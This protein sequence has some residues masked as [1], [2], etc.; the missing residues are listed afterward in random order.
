M[1]LL[2]TIRGR[3]ILLV[4]MLI[5]PAT[6]LVYSLALHNR[7]LHLTEARQRLSFFAQQ[8]SNDLQTVIRDARSIYFAL[9]LVPAIR[10][11][12]LA[13]CADVLAKAHA[14]A[15]ILSTIILTDHT[16]QGLCSA[17]TKEP[18]PSYADREYIQRLLATGALV[19]DRPVIG[20]T[21]KKA[22]VPVAGPV[23]ND[24]GKMVGTLIVPPDL[25]HFGEQFVKEHPIPGLVF[26]LWD[27]DGKL[28][29]RYPDAE[30]LTGKQ[31]ADLPLVHLVAEKTQHGIV[32]VKGFD[33]I[34]RVIG[35]KVPE[36]EYANTGIY[37]GVSMP[38]E[39]FFA[40]ANATMV[41]AFWSMLAITLLG[42]MAAWLLGSRM[43]W[44][45]I[46]KISGVA[47]RFAAGNYRARFGAPYPSGELGE[48][49]HTFDAMADTS[50]DRLGEIERIN[51]ELEQRI[52]DRTTR[53][54]SS[55]MQFRGVLE[56]A[57][58]AF[59]IIDAAGI[60]VIVNAQALALF[61]YTREELLGLP[62]DDLLPEHLRAQHRTHRA[63]YAAA[64]V[65]TIMSKRRDLKGRRKDG[66]EFFAG[67]SLSPLN[68]AQGHF[69]TA[70]VRDITLELEAE[71][72]LKRSNRMLRML[73]VCNEALVRAEDEN[74]LL[75]AICRHI[76]EIGGY[77]LA[78]VG[79]VLHDAAQSV[80][81]AAQF[82]DKGYV[83]QLQI[84][85]ADAER[86]RGPVGRAVREGQTI[87]V[88]DLNRDPNFLPWKSAANAH[89]FVSVIALPLSNRKSVFG[90]LALYSVEQ[91]MFDTDEVNLLVELA[92]DLAYGITSLRETV[93]RQRTQ[94][95]LDYRT[96]YDVLT[97]LPNRAMFID[98]TEQALVHASRHKRHVGVLL[99][100][101][102]RFKG[103]N[104]NYGRAAGDEVLHEIAERLQ[105]TLREGDTVARL[106]VDEFGVLICDLAQTDD[107]LSLGKKLLHVV[108]QPIHFKTSEIDDL[109]VTGSAGVSL[110]PRDG[111]NA[112]GLL[113]AA[114]VAMH[115][116]KSL[117]GNVF[118]FFSEE[119][120]RR[121]STR[122]VLEGALRRAVEQNEL[123][124][125]YQP[126]V[127]LLS[128]ATV[129][130]EA[131]VRWPQPDGSMISP[132]DFIPLAEE[133]GLI[134]P[135]GEWVLNTVCAQMQQWRARQLPVLPIAINLSARQ[136]LQ[137]DLTA[138]IRG[139]LDRHQL[140]PNL[141][142]VEITES[143][144]M[145]NIDKAVNIL[146]EIKAL[147]IMISL[148]DFGTGYSSLN[149]L[150]RFPVNHLKID[151]AFVRDIT[152][153]PD[154]AL[155]CKAVIGLAHNLKMS[156]IAEGV[157]TEGQMNYLRQH[158][159]DE[160]QGYYFSRALPADAFAALLKEGRCLTFRDATE[161]AQ[162]TLLLV[163]DDENML[164]ALKRAMRRSGYRIL[165]AGSAAEGFELLATH[166]VQVIISD[167][168]MPV[169]SGTA[170]LRHVKD[171]YP[172]TVRIV[173]SGYTEL[174]SVTEAINQ[175]AIY[176]FLTKPWDDDDLTEKVK[177]AFHFY[178]M[179]KVEQKD[180]QNTGH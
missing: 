154:D 75:D 162:R 149:Y 136:F 11:K 157:E 111:D 117:G 139:A 65:K 68:T 70:V 7:E 52:I 153:D 54:E 79:F 142:E 8:A 119:M 95:E 90:T 170:F 155:I 123:Q 32:E 113:K 128:G 33:G 174:T 60:I 61:G 69:V 30:Q 12:N 35:Y 41:R 72:A 114:D 66:S 80:Q 115:S 38:A 18:L 23:H 124:V 169:M 6:A 152:T 168:R 48:L 104:E 34:E 101:I 92:N 25:T 175:G 93:A 176:K 116:A 47:R 130:A 63:Q 73:S 37:I 15:P 132:I 165:T 108:A 4:L 28:L 56:S 49:A 50:A 158:R 98:R 172:N 131:L 89:G 9:S 100:D 173:L 135:L 96:S 59:V 46:E 109:F 1:S 57:N 122:V 171:L 178:D 36:G 19:V 99:L 97:G 112:E 87:V 76:V 83:E 138:V 150:K 163:D 179:Q 42:L 91:N 133:T 180:P 24:Q 21:T 88:P 144:A 31:F 3:L 81:P 55:E 86:G 20:R 105:A 134:V 147:G 107:I 145:I 58:D 164:S 151:R 26:L 141:L 53:L 85:W 2:A 74:M 5:L 167:Q 44:Q 103:I 14:N 84:T 29:F 110:Y 156:V 22:V 126:K 67:V 120:N 121:L 161:N 125:H 27:R 160:M 51:T 62:V 146:H 71:N 148:D 10:T 94:S 43:I 143:T 16:G 77:R 127:S 17:T 137:P 166:A 140:Q 118:N 159:C 45:Q 78:W 39:I 106:S 102:D 82:G 129:G 177:E 40:T 64:P 13:E